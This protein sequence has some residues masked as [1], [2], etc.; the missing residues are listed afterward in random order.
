MAVILSII[1][2]VLTAFCIW[3]TVRLFNRPEKWAKRMA[4]AIIVSLPLLY[5]AGFGPWCRLH[6]GGPG[7]I[8]AAPAINGPYLPMFWLMENGPAP[9]RSAI[10]DYCIWCP[11]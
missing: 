4:M 11:S 7:Q 3:L 10:R 6:R 2:V 1:G 9:V 5:I 8:K